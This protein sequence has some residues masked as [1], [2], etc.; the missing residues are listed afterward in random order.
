MGDDLVVI[1]VA[2]NR[3]VADM[4]IEFLG[5]EG[6]LAM[7]RSPGLPSFIGGDMAVEILVS[8]EQEDE[9]RRAISAFLEGTPEGWPDEGEGEPG[10]GGGKRE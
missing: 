7:A 4:I 5:N 1:F 6:I 9:A 8:S 10:E 2:A 3:P